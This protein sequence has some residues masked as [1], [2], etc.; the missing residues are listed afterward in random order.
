MHT[1]LKNVAL[2]V[3]VIGLYLGVRYIG[4]VIHYACADPNEDCAPPIHAVG[5][6]GFYLTGGTLIPLW[7]Q[8]SPFTT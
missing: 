8:N 4:S 6:L 5:Q 2:I 3:I 1:V 7:L